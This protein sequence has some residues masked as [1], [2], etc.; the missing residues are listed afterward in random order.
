M[1][2]NWSVSREVGY[3]IWGMSSRKF[4]H[5]VEEV[6]IVCLRSAFKLGSS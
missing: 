1:A 4:N 6:R 3:W 5:K 2:M